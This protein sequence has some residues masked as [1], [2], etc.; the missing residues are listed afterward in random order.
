MHLSMHSLQITLARDFSVTPPLLLD[1][2]PY[3]THGWLQ[4]QVQEAKLAS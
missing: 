1:H 2:A 3:F 4:C